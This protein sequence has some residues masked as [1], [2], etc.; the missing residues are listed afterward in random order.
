MKNVWYWFKGV[1][2]GVM[3]SDSD[4]LTSG[5]GNPLEKLG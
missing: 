5:D 1:E 3:I 2:D 4:S